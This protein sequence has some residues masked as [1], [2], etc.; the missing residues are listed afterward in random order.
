[1]E[2][3]LR[4]VGLRQGLDGF[5]RTLQQAGDLQHVAELECVLATGM[6]PCQAA[7]GGLLNALGLQPLPERDAQLPVAGFQP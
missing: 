3:Q 6:I 4:P 5:D 2:H 7:E 1:M